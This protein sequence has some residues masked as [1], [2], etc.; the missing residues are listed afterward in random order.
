RLSVML[1]RDKGVNPYYPGE[2]GIV[3]YT[4]TRGGETVTNDVNVK[5]RLYSD[6]RVLDKDFAEGGDIEFQ[7]PSDYSPSGEGNLFMDVEATLDREI[8]GDSSIEIPVSIGDILL[9]PDQWEYEAGDEVYFEYE[10]Q[11][12]GIDEIDSLEYRALDP[13]NELIMS[14]TP[15]DGAFELVIPEN[16]ASSYK[17]ELEAITEGGESIETRERIN[18]VS[19]YFLRTEVV[20]ES[21]YIT[22]V[23]ESGDVIQISYELVS[24]DGTPLPETVKVEY[25]IQGYP[26][27]YYSFRT[28]DTKGTITLTIPELKDGEQL[29][30]IQVNEVGNVEIIDVDNDPSLLNSKV[31]GNVSLSGMMTTILLVIAL[32]LAILALY[33]TLSGRT[34]PRKKPPQTQGIE[35]TQIPPEEEK[36]G[37]GFQIEEGESKQK[38]QWSGVE[39]EKTVDEGQ[40]DSEKEW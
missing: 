20:T 21:D 37:E 26:G 32:I 12:I 8:E 25:R 1:E 15:T 24:R 40:M 27:S 39:Q 38:N 19:G 13:N 3:F 18:H 35:R 31:L 2:E 33:R 14:G 6:Q 23:Y 16:P 34:S 28:N 22:G 36:G 9:N 17:V 30:S 10:F 5:Y 7:V 11:E 29:L 4:V